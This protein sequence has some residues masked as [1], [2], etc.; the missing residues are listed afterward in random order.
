MSTVLILTPIIITNW[1]A[2]VIAATGAAAALGF[3][4]KEEV[5]EALHTEQSNIERSVEVEL[6]D[7][8]V[9]AQ[10]MATDQQI[11]VTK[12]TVQ[13][14]IKRDERGRCVV[15]A[16]GIGHTHAELKLIAE[17]FTNK[18]TQCYVYDRVV[19]ELKNKQFQV[20]NEEVME[21]QSIRVNVRRWVD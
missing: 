3:I 2:I 9:L 6:Q 12:G 11:V 8:Q 4:A 13:I 16:K 10:N 19:K 1:P 21:D 5:K 17:E 20:I 15:S 7:S 14:C 18:L